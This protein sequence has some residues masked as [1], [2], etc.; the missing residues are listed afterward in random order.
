MKTSHCNV[1]GCQKPIKSKG[2]CSAHYERMRKHGSLDE[3]PRGIGPPPN[4]VCLESG[5]AEIGHKRHACS[6]CMLFYFRRHRKTAHA[7]KY[8]LERSRRISSSRPVRARRKVRDAVRSGKLPHPSTQQ[9]SCGQQASQYDHRDYL[10]P[11]MV[12]AV[13]RPCNMRLGRGDNP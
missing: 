6:K 2:F 8:L 11:L 3:R 5:E 12:T 1:P 4:E 9:C 13:C 7:K 10:K